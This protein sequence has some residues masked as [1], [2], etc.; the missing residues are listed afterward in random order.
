MGH[1]PVTIV[2]T[3]PEST[4]KTS[5]AG[6]LGNEFGYGYV[7]EYARKYIEG[8]SRPC[9]YEDVEHIARMQVEQLKHIRTGNPKFIILDTFLVITKVWFL[10]VYGRMPDWLDRSLRESGID[11]F[12][13]CDHDIEWIEDPVRENPGD[14]RVYLSGLYQ[15]EIRS[16][17]LPLEIISG[18]GH[19]RMNR[20]KRILLE[21]F[22]HLKDRL[23]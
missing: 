22:P 18:K 9:T 17:G 15:K 14:R 10:E 1:D 6:F 21:H 7:P 2:I 13:L 20:G 8:L 19:E 16:L 4:G 11:L 5:L 23:I 12:L 3:G